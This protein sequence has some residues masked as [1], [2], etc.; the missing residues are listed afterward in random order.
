VNEK[1]RIITDAG[2]LPCGR[3]FITTRKT[4]GENEAIALLKS[5]T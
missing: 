4:T 3:P 1:G 2:K 5:G